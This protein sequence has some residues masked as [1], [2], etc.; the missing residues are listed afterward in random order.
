MMDPAEPRRSFHATHRRPARTLA[1][2]LALGVGLAPA[3]AVGHEP[4]PGAPVT[5]A[6][7]A[8]VESDEVKAVRAEVASVLASMRAS[9]LAGDTEAYM[10]HV[11]RA[12]SCF[13]HEQRYWANDLKKHVPVSFEFELGEDLAAE[14]DLAT[15]GLTMSWTMRKPDGSEARPRKVTYPVRFV[16]EDGVWRYAGEAW[17]KV[18]GDRVIVFFEGP[19]EEVARGIAD[20]FPGVREKVQEGFEMTVDHVQQIKLY[21]TMRH[22]QAS[23][24]LSY[25]DGLGGW[26][27]PGEAIKQLVGRNTTGESSRTVLAHE[28]GHV[29]TFEMGP[30]ANQMPWWILEGAAELA[31]ESIGRGTKALKS[32]LRKSAREGTL[33]GWD[34]L[35]TFG[36]VKPADQGA[37]YSQGHHMLGFISE[38]FGRTARNAW[39]RSM[40]IG[41]TLDRATREA[42]GVS[43]DELDALWRA[44]LLA[45]EDEPQP[46]PAPA[47]AE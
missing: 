1:G 4:D 18:E 23:I 3:W 30:K 35:T 2:V 19:L 47:A 28:F 45:D 13:I 24:T 17:Q 21:A 16:R 5:V 14:P 37:V 27:E 34:A 10:A 44:A 46:E 29:C 6:A 12:D 36:E 38:R 41:A 39:L 15:V 43:F 31:T 8:R 11:S 40:A 22:L 7:T 26:N 33:R 42:L 20:V 25:T 32:N 9:V